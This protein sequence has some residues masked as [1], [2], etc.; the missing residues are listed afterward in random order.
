M[1]RRKEMVETIVIYCD[2]C[3]EKITDY[4]HTSSMK[5]DGTSLDFH[6]YRKDCFNK[7]KAEEIKKYQ[8]SRKKKRASK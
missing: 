8:E 2:W 3:K 7:Y 4:S 1:S 6:S 5:E